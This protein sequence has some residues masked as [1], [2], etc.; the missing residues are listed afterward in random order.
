LILPR[1]RKRQGFLS[2]FINA[3][4]ELQAFA[5]EKLASLGGK[6]TSPRGRGEEES[7]EMRKT[8]RTTT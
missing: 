4:L 8:T 6:K 5:M 2:S 1:I 3:P 7:R